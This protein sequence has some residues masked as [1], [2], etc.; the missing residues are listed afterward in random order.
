MSRRML[1]KNSFFD[2]FAILIAALPALALLAV[3]IYFLLVGFERKHAL[4]GID[5]DTDR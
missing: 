4:H 5:S 1:H 3:D 2:I